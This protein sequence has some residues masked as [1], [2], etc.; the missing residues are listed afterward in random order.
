MWDT[1]FIVECMIGV[2][3]NQGYPFGGFPVVRIRVF[4]GSPLVVESTLHV[5]LCG[6]SVQ[7]IR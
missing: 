4:M 2:S 3:Q 1:G 6:L 5:K 7:C